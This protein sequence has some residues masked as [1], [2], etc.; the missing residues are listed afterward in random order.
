M[1]NLKKPAMRL[2]VM[3]TILVGLTSCQDKKNILEMTTSENA[4][5]HNCILYLTESANVPIVVDSIELKRYL[6]VNE[7]QTA[8][9][10]MVD[11]TLTP[12]RF[13]KYEY[14][15]YGEIIKTLKYQADL[16][17]LIDNSQNGRNYFYKLRTYDHDRNIIDHL[18]FA[19]WSDHNKR[20]CSGKID[21]DTIVEIKCDENGELKQFKISDL[22]KFHPIE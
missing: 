8:L 5:C 14:K 17:L 12:L 18:D 21:I 4:N 1:R 19:S 13:R 2:F 20:Y 9:D 22:G 16:L 3:L 11:T 7:I 15:N 10:S 6:N